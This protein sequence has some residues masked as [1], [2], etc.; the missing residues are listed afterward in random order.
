MQRAVDAAA[1]AGG[2][3]V[4]VPPGDYRCGTVHLRSHVTVAIGPGAT[5]VA[6]ADH[7]DF[8]PFEDL[9]YPPWADQETHSFTHALLAG[10]DCEHVTIIGPGTIADRG[11]HRIG[12]KPI[13]LKRCDHVT[14]RDVTITGA[15]NY[16][17]RIASIFVPSLDPTATWTRGTT[18]SASRRVCHW[19]MPGRPST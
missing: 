17:I 3:T 4:W 19:V 1:T 10:L 12:P 5:L 9:P 13:A 8:D 16:A 18:P 15:P 6:S 2:G 7:R 11:G 14:I